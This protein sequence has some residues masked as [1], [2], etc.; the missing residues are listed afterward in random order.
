MRILVVD[1]EQ[2]VRDAYSHIL[3]GNKNDNAGSLTRELDREL[4]GAGADSS[5]FVEEYSD[6]LGFEVTYAK[7]G[8]EAVALV[9][10]ALAQGKPYKAAFIDVRM[11]PGIDGKETAHRIRNIDPDVNIVIVTA[12]S[13]HS[14]TDIAAVASPPHKIFY[15]QKPFAAAEVRQMAQA[16]V[17]RWDHDTRQLEQLREKMVELAASEARA[18]HMANHDLLTGVPNRLAFQSE[19]VR[20]KEK[21]CEGLF[22]AFLGLR[23]LNYVT[24]IFGHDAGD[25]LLSTIVAELNTKV[26]PNVL[27]ARITSDQFAFLFR[28]PSAQSA[29]EYL[30]SVMAVCTGNKTVFEQALQL[31]ASCGL[32]DC[33]KAGDADVQDLLRFAELALVEADASGSA[34][35]CLFNPDLDTSKRFRQRLEE[36]LVRAMEKDEFVLHYQPII[37]SDTRERVGYEALLRWSSPEFGPVSP[38]VFIPIAE[39]CGMIDRIGDW[40]I[41]R[42][43][44][45][46]RSWPDMLTS[47]NVSPR[48]FDRADWIPHLVRQAREFGIAPRKVQLEITETALF[49]NLEDTS[50]KLAELRALGFRVALDDFGTG[51]SSMC[52]LKDFEVDCVKIDRS[53]VA[54]MDHDKQSAKIV[55]AIGQLAQSLGLITV[56]EGIESEEQYRLVQ[57]AHCGYMQGYLFGTPKSAAECVASQ[58]H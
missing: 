21:G 58:T 30:L 18:H 9:E 29:Q 32:V 33:S 22:L 26:P 6:H 51:F 48:Q 37:F 3:Q 5:S 40:V 35:I 49:Q 28:S 38:A 54:G 14:V 42:A 27:L 19:L 34:K 8:L 46:A 44:S 43:L 1:D 17:E 41:T 24:E 55:G 4:F 20:Q 11:P 23:R 36:G 25:E 2:T 47:I 45:D 7:Q 31:G 53:F 13:D 16:L 56:A 12:Y 57:Q 52:N 39:E 50:A 10:A 15:I